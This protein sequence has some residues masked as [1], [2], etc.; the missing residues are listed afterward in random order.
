LLI[1][2]GADLGVIELNQEAFKRMQCEKA[3]KIVPGATHLFEERGTLE[4]VQELAAAWFTAHMAHAEQ[5]ASE[6]TV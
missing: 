2:G 5:T 4:Q 6:H 1:V 3:L